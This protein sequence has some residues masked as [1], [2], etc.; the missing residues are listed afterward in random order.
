MYPVEVDLSK[1][2]VPQVVVSSFLNP[3]SSVKVLV[4]SNQIA[5]SKT[6]KPTPDIISAT[7]TDVNNNLIFRLSTYTNK[8]KLYLISNDLKPK[9]GG[10]YKIRVE[11]KNPTAIVEVTDTVPSQKVKIVQLKNNPIKKDFLHSCS[12]SFIPVQSPKVV[13]YELV[14]YKQHLQTIE[15]DQYHQTT[16]KS[17]DYLITREDYYPD[18]FMLEANNP[19]SLLFRLD[20][21][22]DIVN[23]NFVYDAPFVTNGVP[24]ISTFDHNIKIQ[25]RTVSRSYFKYKTTLCTQEYAAQGDLLYGMPEPVKVFSNIKGGLGIMG[26]YCK[27]D[28]TIWVAG[29]PNVDKD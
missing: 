22:K 27:T 2:Y 29:R 26:S 5:F 18:V 24:I 8:E 10:V 12:F 25:L 20:S 16:I 9:Q 3:D 23:I 15:P 1:D 4:G 11:T 19:I 13:Y 6:I 14:L 7:I 28:T 21:I 17:N